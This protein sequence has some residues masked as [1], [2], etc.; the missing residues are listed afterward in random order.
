MKILITKSQN[1]MKLEFNNIYQRER[2][3]QTIFFSL[4][5]IFESIKAYENI[6]GFLYSGKLRSIFF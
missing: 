5:N 6:F 4:Q 2:E 1:S 3:D